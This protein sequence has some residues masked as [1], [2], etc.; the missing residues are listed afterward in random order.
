MDKIFLNSICTETI[1][2]IR[3]I[4]RK[5]KQRVLISLELSSDL[6]TPG[7]TDNLKD[8]VDY[9]SLKNSIV[10]YTE[11]S[12]FFLLEALAAGIAEICL[13]LEKVHEVRVKIEK[14]DVYNDTE[15]VGVEITRRKD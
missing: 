11:E 8:T 14:P 7:K 4:E 13:V 3:P 6:D 5:K 9:S 10:R 1:I 15:S 12:T 2:G